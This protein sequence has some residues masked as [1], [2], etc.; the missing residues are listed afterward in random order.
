MQDLPHLQQAARGLS[1]ALADPRLG[2]CAPGLPDGRKLMLG[3]LPARRIEEALRKATAHAATEGAT[4]LLALLGHGFVPG[5]VP[6]L[7]LMG[8]DSVEG[9]EDS[10]VNVREVLA[11]AADKTGLNGVLAVIDTCAAAGAMPP[12]PELSMGQLNGQT[13]LGLL[14][15]TGVDQP[16]Y[17]MTLSRELA[18]VIGEGVTEA[19][20]LLDLQ[21]IAA[22]LTPR[23]T[24]Q[25]VIFLEY[26]GGQGG[27]PLWLA[28]NRRWKTGRSDGG[29]QG[30]G[31]PGRAALAVV[32][33]VL[34]AEDRG[35][36]DWTLSDAYHLP[37][38]CDRLRALPAAPTRDS[39]IRVLTCL[40]NAHE[41]C[42]VLRSLLPT[43]LT[44]RRLRRAMAGAG[45]LS[46]QPLPGPAALTEVDAAEHVALRVPPDEPGQCEAALTRFLVELAYDGGADLQAPELRDWVS[47]HDTLVAYNEAVDSCERRS[48]PADRLRLIVALS[49]PTGDWPE[50]L[51]AW[52]LLDGAIRDTRVIYCAPDRPGAEEALAAGVDWA[53]DHADSL[54]L[55]LC[56]IDVAVPAKIMLQWRPEQLDYGEL[57]GL[58][59]R[60]LIRWSGR[61]DPA[62]QALRLNRL[63]WQ[64]LAQPTAVTGGGRLSWLP[65]RQ[66]SDPGE[67]RDAFRM[68]RY[69]KAIGLLDDP[70][71]NDQLFEVLLQFSSVL[72]WPQHTGAGPEHRR[73][74]D[75]EWDDLPLGFLLAYRDRWRGGASGANV[76]ADLRTVW[77]DHDWL[78]FCASLRP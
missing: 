4:L 78:A 10:A 11:R 56:H 26:G 48:A 24:D 64:R 9:D 21:K 19:G 31:A 41:A 67:V 58:G 35:Q 43:K 1:A 46:S 74:V 69:P 16:A 17:D 3:D 47:A 32:L 23:I 14:M 8:C 76:M 39:A 59:H 71:A 49:S 52:L 51:D 65:A 72:I 50:Q 18:A 7:Y 70:G 57:L 55:E 27:E 75:Q 13:R 12:A 54:D 45:A 40:V 2:A 53:K 60:V 63:A 34:G 62:R 73:R 20:P 66:C 29:L 44:R 30:L 77:D 38:L 42:A 25:N 5:S 22:V 28:H 15:A 6:K 61:L 36:G 68:G 37:G 33:D